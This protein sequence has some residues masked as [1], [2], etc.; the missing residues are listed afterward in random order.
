[1]A[2]Y[3]D[4][5]TR[6]KANLSPLPSPIRVRFMAVILPDS[7]KKV[8]RFQGHL[9]RLMPALVIIE[10]YAGLFFFIAIK[11]NPTIIDRTIKTIKLVMT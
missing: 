8:T 3:F 9:H 4:L 10:S 2:T 7:V 11:I 6:Q 5:F 1:M